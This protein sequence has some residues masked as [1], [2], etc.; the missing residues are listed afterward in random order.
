MYLNLRLI[1]PWLL[2][3]DINCAWIMWWI[4]VSHIIPDLHDLGHINIYSW[5]R[6]C[7]FAYF[8]NY[9]IESLLRRVMLVREFLSYQV[10]T[11]LRKYRAN[12]AQTSILKSLNI[13][14]TD[15]YIGWKGSIQFEFSGRK[16][17][18]CTLILLNKWNFGYSFSERSSLLPILSI[19]HYP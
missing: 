6:C 11:L 18:S 16:K 13:F 19:T 10:I 4:W 12:L 17:Y 9:F 14:W 5:L 7:Y 8:I 15:S 1:P 3:R 2:D